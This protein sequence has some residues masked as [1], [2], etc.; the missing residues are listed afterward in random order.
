MRKEGDVHG[1]AG[2]GCSTWDERLTSTL[3]AGME[4]RQARSAEG[5]TWPLD[6]IKRCSTANQKSDP[7]LLSIVVEDT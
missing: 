3:A 5:T 6:P 2:R 1:T 7:A 4:T